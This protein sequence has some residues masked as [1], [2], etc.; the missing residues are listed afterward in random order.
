MNIKFL[1]CYVIKLIFKKIIYLP[2]SIKN[3]TKQKFIF[4]NMLGKLTVKIKFP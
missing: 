2:N 4:K 1:P 3:L